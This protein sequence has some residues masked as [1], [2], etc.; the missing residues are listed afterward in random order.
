MVENDSQI[1]EFRRVRQLTSKDVEAQKMYTLINLAYSAFDDWK[2]E[3]DQSK[4][5]RV[6]FLSFLS[7]IFAVQVLFANAVLAVLL[8]TEYAIDAWIGSVFFAGVFAKTSAMLFWVVRYL[9]YKGEDRL[10]KA[11]TDSVRMSETRESR[12]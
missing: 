10:L 2:N 5:Y 9:F 1:P 11:L 7:W 12:S 3:R 4:Q 6:K 8:F